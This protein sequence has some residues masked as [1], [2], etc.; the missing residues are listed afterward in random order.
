MSS[1]NAIKT[2]KE[3]DK[4]MAA[5]RKK[6]IKVKIENGRA[7]AAE[8]QK[9]LQEIQLKEIRIESIKGEISTYRVMLKNLNRKGIRKMENNIYNGSSTN[10][11]ASTAESVVKETKSR[12]P[13][14]TNEEKKAALIGQISRKEGDIKKIEG[15]IAVLKE[16]IKAIDQQERDKDLKAISELLSKKNIDPKELIKELVEKNNKE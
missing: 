12:K 6:N 13:R 8:I 11:V 3:K 4:I 7:A 16:K 5:E 14:A 10:N 1:R 15:E 2:P 9:L